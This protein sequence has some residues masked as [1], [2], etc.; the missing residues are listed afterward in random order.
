MTRIPRIVTKG[1]GSITAEV[2]GFTSGGYFHFP[3]GNSF[4]VAAGVSRLIS[5]DGAD[6]RP[7][8]RKLCALHSAHKT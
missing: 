4:M 3:L 6:Q 8:P 2:D 7:L 5:Q 1:I